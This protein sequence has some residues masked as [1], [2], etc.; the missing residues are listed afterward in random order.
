MVIPKPILQDK[1]LAKRKRTIWRMSELR[2][3]CD[4]VDRDFPQFRNQ[5][6]PL[7]PMLPSNLQSRLPWAAAEYRL[8]TPRACL[9]YG[10]RDRLGRKNL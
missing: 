6:R 10:R 4:Q 7:P 1:P 8:Q 5:L 2:T 9:E 3:L